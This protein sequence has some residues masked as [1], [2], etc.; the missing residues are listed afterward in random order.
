MTL[1][2]TQLA[3][4]LHRPARL[5]LTGLAV[6]V[7]AFVVFATVLAHRTLERTVLDSHRGT[8]EAADI[9]V[10]TLDAPVQGDAL[11][12]VRQV[13]GVAE[14]QARTTAFVALREATGTGGTGMS[15]TADPGTGPLSLV[16]LVEGA[17]PE[18]PGEIALTARAAGRLETGIGDTITVLTGPDS[19]RPVT[20]KITG[21]AA[22]T[23]DTPTING[24]GGEQ[25]FAPDTTVTSLTGPDSDL[26]QIEVRLTDG[27]DAGEVRTL[28]GTAVGTPGSVVP[29]DEVR[30][31]EKRGIIDGYGVVFTVVS[32]F[33]TVAVL[34]AMLVAASA[35]RIVLTQRVRQL[36]LLRAVGADP[37]PLA[38][39]LAAEGALTGAVAGTAGVGAAG[40]AAN[41]LPYALRLFGIRLSAPGLPLGP[42]LAVVLGAVALTAIAVLSPAASASRTSPM[43]ALRTASTSAARQGI[44]RARAVGGGFLA[45]VALLLAVLAAR[46]LPEPGHEDYDGKLVLLL[47]VFSGALAFWALVML[48]PV[49]I[50]PVLHVV[51]WPLRRTGPVG[52]LAVG[53]VGA[54]TRRAAAV[55]VVVALG[56]TMTGTVLTGAQSMR[57]MAERNIAAVAPSDFWL[58]SGTFEPLPPALVRQVG[59][60]ETLS[61][62]L[63]QRSA[64]VRIGDLPQEGQA[65]DLDLR[66]LSTWGQYRAHSGSLDDIGPGRAALIGDSAE[67]AGVGIGDRVTLTRGRHSTEVKVVAIV[68]A[69]P[70]DADV[71]TDPADLDRLGLPAG[72]TG[73]V[74]DA[75]ASG[76][77]GRTDALKALRAAIGPQDEAYV[78]VLADDR[79][80]STADLG[81]V[82]GGGLALIALTVLIAVTGVGSTTALS[83]TERVREAGLLRAVGLSRGGLTGALTLEA[84]LYG[85]IGAA[86]GL[87]LAVPYSWLL[88]NA[89]GANTPVEYPVL[90]LL[91][92]VLALAALTGLAGALPARRAAR[93]SPVTA[94][95]VDG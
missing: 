4:A 92:V 39:A 28:L 60:E 53:G 13:P 82:L 49:L 83:V 59:E 27:A 79:D 75:A 8:P 38:R 64:L 50:R 43:Q 15:V 14:A 19:D 40:L 69:A 88:V 31:R 33:L 89:T 41:L 20:L 91:G 9:V 93:V 80:S 26:D 46:Q 34:A 10:G 18:A 37:E 52:R 63:P 55:S 7:A 5:L 62:V 81:I 21:L 25:A 32:V 76:E 87:L 11:P 94:L 73:L 51:G 42:A 29:A 72:P 16:R 48:G 22:A 58:D 2:R 17:Y 6:A 70:L 23:V 67:G 71:L 95:A 47:I 86:L 3:G 90:Q 61:R 78:E 12:E 68:Q 1:L 45:G 36:A 54:A 66:K 30:D 77:Q 35:F 74:A 65:V 24:L 84:A 85:V 56:V 57:V 44:G